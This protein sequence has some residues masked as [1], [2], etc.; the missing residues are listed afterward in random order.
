L[1]EKVLH[2]L[3]L[4]TELILSIL[5]SLLLGFNAVFS[6]SVQGPA[7]AVGN[8]YF[9]SWLAFFLCVRICLGCVEELHNLNDHDAP[10][11]DQA[12]KQSEQDTP[13]VDP[14]EKDRVK[15]LR[16][17]FFLAIFSLV[18]GASAYDAASVNQRQQ[19]L[20]K[21]QLYLM[22]A[23]CV[24]AAVSAILFVLC[25]SRRCY[26][27]VSSFCVGGVLSILC[28]GLW[29]GALV[30]TMHS[31]YSWAV[32]SVGEIVIANLYFYSWAG[33]LSAGLLMMSYVNALFKVKHP[34]YMSIVWVAICKVCF[35]IL[36]A[37]LHV[38]HTIGDNCD[39]DEITSGAVTFCSRTVLAIVVSL[40]GMLVGGLVVFGRVMVT[41][42][43]GCGC[44]GPRTQA[45]V[46]MIVSMFLVLLFSATVALVTGIGGP[47][48]SVGDLFFSTW[49]SFAV[50]LGIFVQ[51]EAQVRKDYTPLVQQQEQSNQYEPP[52]PEKGRTVLLAPVNGSVTV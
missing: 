39:L 24:V 26:M 18:C 50:A 32:N 10:K 49:V 6:T 47:G 35:V 3:P 2:R 1:E 16:S 31:E 52:V 28:F 44:I 46:E 37:A 25:L 17:Y 33:I 27:I 12:S 36:G 43:G 9:A 41:L 51:C 45:H 38:W 14:I 23:P 13:P 30:L 42:C 19:E 11:D 20:S 22:L 48:Q 29:L 21:V 15:R 34:D 8:L 7:A 5:L 40:A 4:T